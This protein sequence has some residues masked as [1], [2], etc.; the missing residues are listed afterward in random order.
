MAAIP[1]DLLDRIRAL[2]REV[3]T[4]AGR[5]QIRPALNEITSG[6]VKIA[7]GGSLEVWSPTGTGLFRV[8][9]FGP[10]FNHPDKTAQQGFVMNREDGTL[11]LSIL[12]WPSAELGGAGT[13]SISLWD[14]EGN[15]V[16]SD[17]T[18]SGRFL[19]AP[20][21]PLPF[22]R[23]AVDNVIT[24]SSFLNVWFATVQA[25]NPVASIQL[26]FGA[27][28]GSTCE[29]VVQYRTGGESGWSNMATLSVTA[30]PQ[31]VAW[32]TEWVTFPLHRARFEQLVFI[33][34]QVRQKSG[35]SGVI[36]N[37]LGAFTRRSYSNDDIPDPPPTTL[38]A[39]AMPGPDG[40]E[41]SE[42]APG[43]GAEYPYQPPPPPAGPLIPE[44]N[45]TQTETDPASP[46]PG[47]RTIDD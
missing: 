22:Q 38:A 7:E 46:E 13:Q 9:S 35:T 47:L 29:V 43:E 15:I 10:F 2:E 32:K 36:C 40:A 24:N 19:G 8:G 14:R 42:A 37:L 28:G 31:D 3:R 39:R 17:D 26:E 30:P 1:L 12:A 16:L 5:A 18:T 33:R 41:Q 45:P 4:L 20:A 27:G 21:L 11:A 44:A 23:L 6:L 34:V 25:H